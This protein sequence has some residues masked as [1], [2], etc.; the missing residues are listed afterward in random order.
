MTIENT[1]VALARRAA[2]ALEA[3]DQ[4]AP[5]QRPPGS[6][7]FGWTVDVLDELARVAGLVGRAVDHT[8]G[9][10]CPEV[11]RAAQDLVDAIVAHRNTTLQPARHAAADVRAAHEDR[12][13]RDYAPP[14]ART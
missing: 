7:R 2:E 11:R 14:A 1:G 4:H 8:S 12:T 9:D 13:R 6:D 10:A 5:H 3:L